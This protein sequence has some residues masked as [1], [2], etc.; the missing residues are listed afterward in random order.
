VFEDV[1]LAGL[2]GQT[3][4]AADPLPADVDIILEAIKNRAAGAH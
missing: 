1:G 3:V 2:D 4:T